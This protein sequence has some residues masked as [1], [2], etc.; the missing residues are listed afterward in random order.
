MLILWRL[1]SI[2]LENSKIA[3]N[4]KEIDQNIKNVSNLLKL[5]I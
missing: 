4:Q 1:S 5:S 2:F 3:Q